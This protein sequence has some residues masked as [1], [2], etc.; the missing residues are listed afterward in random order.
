M[1]GARAAAFAVLALL[2]GPSA[3]QDFASA[4]SGFDTGSAVPIQIEA[5]ELEVRD[6]EKLAIYSGEVRVQQGETILE[7]PALRI[8]YSGEAP[9]AGVPGSQVSRLE[10]GPGVMVRSGDRTASGDRAVLD[11]ETDVI[12]MSG[13]V[14]L[15]EG[16]NVVRGERLI[17]NL[18]TKQGRI[19]GGRVQ[20]LI[21]PSGAGRTPP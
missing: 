21:T 16:Q 11:M 2:A 5:D 17:V 6:E 10:A 12:T 19:E 4:F 7:T 9:A 18:A 20:T 15:T 3:A 8:F 1:R 14:V 13:N